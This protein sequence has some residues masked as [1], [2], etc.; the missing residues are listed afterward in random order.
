MFRK[1]IFLGLMIMLGTVLVMLVVQARRQETL[2]AQTPLPGEIVKT[3][4]ATATRVMA[5]GDLLVIESDGDA[6]GG[7]GTRADDTPSTVFGRWAIRNG[8]PIAYHNTMLKITCLGNGGKILEIRTRLL[9]ETIP[10]GQTLS[11]A[12]I[13]IEPLPARTIRCTASILY[14]EVGAAPP[15]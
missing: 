14:A 11:L 15:Q 10:S 12:D 7:A 5:P 13:A 3:A 4:R 2:R 6:A 9:P 8:G 1:Y